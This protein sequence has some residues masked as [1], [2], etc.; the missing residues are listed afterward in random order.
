MQASTVVLSEHWSEIFS[1]YFEGVRSIQNPISPTLQCSMAVRDTEHLL[2]LGRNDSVK[3]HQF[4]IAVAKALRERRPGV[5]LSLTGIS[6]S[7]ETWVDSLGWVSEEEKNRLLQSASILLVPSL[8]EGQPLVVIEA[9]ASGLPVLVSDSVHS[10]PDLVT[11][12]RSQDVDDWVEKLDVILDRKTNPV[13]LS[14][15]VSNHRIDTVKDQWHSL[16]DGLSG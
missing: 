3:G 14:E 13:A 11:H 16:Y 5:R 10:I 1:E 4:A 6:H 15:S 12:A 2:L 9:L 7:T 8:F